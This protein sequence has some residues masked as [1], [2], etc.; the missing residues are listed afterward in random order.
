MSATTAP[1]SLTELRTPGEIRRARIIGI[2]YLVLAAFVLFVFAVGTEGNSTFGLARAGDRFENF[3]NLVLPS[4]GLG[5]VTAVLA[6]FGGIQL[7]RGFGKRSTL[8]LGSAL[9]L[10]L[11]FSGM[12]CG[13]QGVQPGRHVATLGPQE[14]ADHVRSVVGGDVRAGGGDQYRD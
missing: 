10:W 11:R 12:G 13:R 5:Y 2:I 14:R 3:P 6:F 4:A 8:V 9:L 1:T 7:T